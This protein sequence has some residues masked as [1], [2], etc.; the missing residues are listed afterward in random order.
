MV[1]DHQ[2]TATEA[3]GPIDHL[4]AVDLVRALDLG[5][6]EGPVLDAVLLRHRPRP[7]AR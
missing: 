7:V 4:G 1:L 5:R 3:V 2:R 6:L